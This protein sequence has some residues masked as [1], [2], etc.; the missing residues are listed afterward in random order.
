MWRHHYQLSTHSCIHPV[1]PT[2]KMD[3]GSKPKSILFGA[4]SEYHLLFRA[5]LNRFVEIDINI[6]K[7]LP[8]NAM[9]DTPSALHPPC[10]DCVQLVLVAE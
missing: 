10:V 7:M 9:N 4:F 1:R 5:F 2:V 6:G 3:P 8:L